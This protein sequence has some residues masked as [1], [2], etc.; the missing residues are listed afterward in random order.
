MI[1]QTIS[2]YRILEKLGSGGMGVVYKAEDLTLHRFVALKFLPDDVAEDPQALFRFQREARAASM[3]NHPNICTIYEIGEEA[4]RPYIAMEFLDGETLGRRIAGKLPELE[5]LLS[6]ATEIADAL[7]AAHTAGVIHRDIKPAN[8]FITKHGAKILDFGLATVTPHAGVIDSNRTTIAA[9]HLTSPGSL[10]GTVGYMSP[11]QVRGKELDARSDLFSFGAVLYEMA[12]GAQPFHGESSVVVCEMILNR[13]PAPP[14]RLNPGMSP[15]LERI[16]DKALEKD[17]NLRYQHAADLRADLKRLK[18]DSSRNRQE[19][20]LPESMSA[21][22]GTGTAAGPAPTT[23]PPVATRSGRK[24]YYTIAAIF[25]VLAAV[26]GILFWL[27]NSTP[28]RPPASNQWEQL[29]FFTDSAVYPALSSDGRMLAFIRGSESFIAAGDIYVKMLPSGEPVQLTHDAKAKLAPAFSPDN[30]LIAYSVIEPWDTWE[31][32]VL[33]GAPRL[34]MPNSSSVSWIDGGKRLLFS[35]IKSGSGLHMGVVVTDL[36]RGNSRDVYLPAGTRSMAHHSY[37]SPDGRWVLVVQMD[38]QGNIL[39][40]RVVP[41]QGT[42]EPKVVGPHGTCLAGAWSPDGQWIYVSAKSN[43]SRLGHPTNDFHLWRQH[44]PDGEPEQITFGPTSQQG[45]AMAPD[46]KSII[47]SVGTEDD[48]VWLHDKDGDHQISSEGNTSDPIFSSDGRSFYFLK[49]NGSTGNQEL[50]A[51]DLASGN[52]GGVLPGVSMQSYSVSHDGKMVAFV[53]TDASGHQGLWIAP[54]SRRSAPVRLS[55]ASAVEDSPFFLPDGDIIFRSSEGGS[56][57]IY[58]MKADGTGRQKLNSQRILDL[59]GVSPDG[60]WVVAVVPTSDQELT[61]SLAAFSVDGHT[62]VALC[63]GYCSANWDASG[64]YIYVY[65]PRVLGK[66]TYIIPVKDDVELPVKL[67][68]AD[69]VKNKKGLTSVPWLVQSGNGPSIYAYVRV[70]TR[71]NL[72]RIP[73]Q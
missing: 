71:S 30:S 57:Y 24:G 37:L 7:D 2:R 31:V 53:T 12:T 63:A 15:E 48:S 49:T 13:D 8:I 28:G 42:A 9:D 51:M 40:C 58:R 21:D 34:F 41:F 46:G 60:R 35:E 64:K 32:P 27:H 22:P 50:W 54:T 59:Y 70:T 69:D 19:M 11:E 62:A 23:T 14:V 4:G 6:L 47:T 36:D 16:I 5:L 18:R 3:L 10:M 67:A 68:H 17:P 61:A 55:P 39:P 66:N 65:Y 45:I 38:N 20:G 72:Y 44:W 56:N 29:T 43:N 73:L 33:G 1:G 52:M 26:G 25:F